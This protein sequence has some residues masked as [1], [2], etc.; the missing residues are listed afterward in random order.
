MR[1]VVLVEGVSDQLAVQALARR[2]GLDLAADGVAVLPMGG[3]TNIGH[4]LQRYGPPGL[5]LPVAGL[6]DEA[7]ARFFRRGLERVGIGDDLSIAEM[8]SAGFFVCIADL[9]D[10]LIRALG[11]AAVE[12]IIDAQGDLSSLRILQQQPDQREKTDQAR[13]RR[14]MGTRGGR[15]IAYAPV[16]VDALDLDRVP[17][18]LDGLLQHLGRA[19]SGILR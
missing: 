3:A 16:L 12:Q 6:Y 18:P 7:E 2:R 14:F 15:K 19:E 11:I 10:E 5:D 8:E 9:E 4:F 17:P 13:L 1:A